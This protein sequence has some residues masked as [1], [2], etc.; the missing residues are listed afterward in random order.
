MSETLYPFDNYLCDEKTMM[1]AAG[2]HAVAI[3]GKEWRFA[4]SHYKGYG[5]VWLK[6][7]WTPR[8]CQFPADRRIWAAYEEWNEG[9]IDKASS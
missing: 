6:R 9:R 1:P 4:Y 7:D 5:P 3:D 8:R 2:T